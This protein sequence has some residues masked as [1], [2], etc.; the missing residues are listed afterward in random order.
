MELIIIRQIKKVFFHWLE[1][2]ALIFEK[3]GDPVLVNVTQVAPTQCISC[4]SKMISL[5]MVDGQSDVLLG[6]CL[7]DIPDTGLE[8][9]IPALAC[10]K[11]DNCSYIATEQVNQLMCKVG[12]P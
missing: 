10:L 9:G 1:G 7:P 6:A 11:N 12:R 8:E 2:D 4:V 3:R 5:D